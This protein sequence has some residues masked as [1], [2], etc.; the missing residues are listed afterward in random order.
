MREFPAKP[1][2]WY[3]KRKLFGP[4]SGNRSTQIERHAHTRRERGIM[5][6]VPAAVL[7]FGTVIS[8]H[9]IA[10]SFQ[11]RDK[12]FRRRAC[13]SPNRIPVSS[14]ITTRGRSAGDRLWL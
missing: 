9:C 10:P 6:P 8:P 5:R 3:G 11:A 7:L 13:V 4:A 1:I 12:S 2:L 14:E